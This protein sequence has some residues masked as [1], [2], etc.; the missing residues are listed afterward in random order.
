MFST[1][2]CRIGDCLLTVES[3]VDAGEEFAELNCDI[4]SANPVERGLFGEGAGA[5]DG[6]CVLLP[7][8]GSVAGSIAGGGGTTAGGGAGADTART[9]EGTG[10][11][12]GAGGGGVCLA[13]AE[14]W[15]GGSGGETLAAAVFFGRLHWEGEV[16][17]L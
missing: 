12:T 14:D 9:G 6:V 2:F 8:R 11:C 16:L 13:V 17:R 15:G 1:T 4:L 10:I 3:F 5:G 7:Q